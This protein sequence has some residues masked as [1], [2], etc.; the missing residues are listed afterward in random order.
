MNK[1]IAQQTS[2]IITLSDAYIV[3]SPAVLMTLEQPFSKQTA[4]RLSRL[5]RSVSS[6]GLFVSGGRHAPATCFYCRR[7]QWKLRKADSQKAVR[8]APRRRP[9]VRAGRW[10]PVMTCPSPESN[11]GGGVMLPLARERPIRGIGAELLDSFRPAYVTRVSRV[12][13]GCQK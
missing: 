8:N 10:C 4:L 6:E 9:A 7:Q 11:P 2:C 3:F 1:L 13:A 5:Q 12:R